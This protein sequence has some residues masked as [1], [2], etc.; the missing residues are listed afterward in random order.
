M[1]TGIEAGAL[2]ATAT[3]APARRAGPGLGLAHLRR[4]ALACV[5]P[6]ALVAVWQI[7]TAGRPYSLIPPPAEVWAELQ[8]LA[9]GGINDDA[10]SG[11]LWTHLVA[12]LS[13]VYGGFALAA[14]AALP[15]G[16]LIGRVP[17]IRALLDPVL[18]V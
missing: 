5:V 10:F 8:D 15:L 14:A 9:V 16:L 4:L 7:T 17:L 3:P 12:S 13:R 11:T 1:S 6:A 2:P 18:Q